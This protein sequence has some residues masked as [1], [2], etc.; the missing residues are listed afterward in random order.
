MAEIVID[1]TVQF[2][3]DKLIEI[4]TQEWRLVSGF[5]SELN[6]LKESLAMIKAFLQDAARRQ[7]E[8]ETIRLWL[9]KL[10]DVAYEAEN[11]FDELEYENI[12]RKVEINNQM[13]RKVCFY[14]SLSNPLAFR[15]KMA[16]KISEVN[17]KLK[18]I[19]EKANN[20][21]LASVINA[22]SA[23]FLPSV[24]ETDSISRDPIFVGRESDKSKIIDMLM[25]PSNE[26]ISVIPIVGMGG[27]GKTTLA[28]KIFNDQQIIDYFDKTIWVCVSENFN[29]TKIFGSI[30]ESLDKDHRV[31]SRQAI[32]KSLQEILKNKK[33]LL[34]VDDL[35]NDDRDR[36]DD[37]QNSL[38]GINSNTGNFILVTTRNKDVASIVSRPCMHYELDNL[39]DDSCWSIIERKA[40]SGGEVPEELKIIGKEIAQRCRGHPL[41]ANMV[42]GILQGKRRDDWVS[43]LEGAFSDSNEISDSNE[44][45]SSVMRVLKVSFNRLPSLLLQKC[46]AYCSIFPKDE[47]IN[48]KL[49][50]QLWMAEGFLRDNEND[51]ESRGNKVCEILLQHSF[52][53]EAVKDETGII[54][55]CKMHDLVHDLACLVSDTKSL[56]VGNRCIEHKSSRCRY[57]VMDSPDLEPYNVIQDGAIY[58]RTLFLKGNVLDQ[59]LQNFRGLHILVLQGSNIEELNTSIGKLIHLRLL[60]VSCT[61]INTL[62]VSV[63]KLFHL[64]TL[65]ANPCSDLHAFPDKLQQLINLR[66]LHVDKTQ[67]TPVN[68]GKLTSLR[69]LEFFNVGVEKGRRIEELGGLK[70]LMGELRI[71]NLDLVND[72]EEAKRASLIEKPNLERLELVWSNDSSDG[73]NNHEQVL[74]GLQPHQN[75]KSLKIEN[76]MGDHF[77]SWTMNMGVNCDQVRL[78]NLTEIIL[79]NCNRCREIPT[80]GTLPLLEILYV[81]GMQGLRS[82]EPSFYHNIPPNGS[83]SSNQRSSSPTV[84]FPALKKLRLMGM[85]SLVGWVGPDEMQAI[86]F[87]VLEYLEVSYCPLLLAAPSHGFPSLKEVVITNSGFPSLERFS[88]CGIRNLDPDHFSIPHSKCLTYLMLDNCDGLI[89]L[90]FPHSK[91]LET[92][93]I[94]GCESLSSISFP[95]GLTSLKSMEIGSC[96]SLTNLPCE[97]LDNCISLESLAVMNCRELSPFSVERMVCLSSL[98]ITDCPNIRSLPKGIE[99]GRLTELE[100]GPIIEEEFMLDG[101]QQHSLQKLTLIGSNSDS[102]LP[103][104]IQ[105]FTSLKEL[106]LN[107]FGIEALPEWL[108]NLSSLQE[109]I[110]RLC[111]KLKH[112]P[113]KEVM[114]LHLTK[115]QSLEI[116]WCNLLI[117]RC[118][119]E[120]TDSE[121]PKISHIP[122]LNISNFNR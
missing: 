77:P 52:F 59:M 17:E 107:G 93:V 66:H 78:D 104:Q 98:T 5:K 50:I 81:V 90:K 111:G 91:C 2:A 94:S 64:Q 35:W 39:S 65:R 110:L 122:K 87:P 4:A 85:L 70:Y 22:S 23:S 8:E 11:L 76:F 68:I 82:I 49:L 34:V 117:E 106:E 40:F 46:F 41:A 1:A 69:T 10:E 28:R 103:Y 32:L 120:L 21:G 100:F 14:F 96:G 26:V 84:F 62:P 115:L 79:M 63:C 97:M 119:P 113:S 86:A 43:I 15:W 7:V 19:E 53:Q 102:P 16:H 31:E 71:C 24:E 109:L 80:L 51:M 121:W 6:N 61:K 44:K 60:D 36:W 38:S 92:L 30:L 74:E 67:R 42:G 112:L 108:G 20:Y 88:G 83:S 13:K 37:F 118:N 105:H 116:H 25:T 29:S 47:Q 101:L 72:R 56:K 12:R 57:L 55:Y 99:F 114:Q 45:E 95:N 18:K 48:T 9:K 89:S 3:V 75:I 58:L 33:Y 27:L 54:T 73:D